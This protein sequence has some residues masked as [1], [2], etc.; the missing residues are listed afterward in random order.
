MPVS[1]AGAYPASRARGFWKRTTGLSAELVRLGF[2][3]GDELASKA[4]GRF[5]IE[6][7]PHAAAVQLFALDRIV[8]YKKGTLAARP[9][10]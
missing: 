5:Q 1:H 10:S 3:H 4:P 2:G 7:Y 6:V 9:D 8:K